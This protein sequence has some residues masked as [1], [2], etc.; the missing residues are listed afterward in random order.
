MN[1]SAM[2][3]YVRRLLNEEGESD[4]F[5][6]DSELTDYINEAYRELIRI[7][8]ADKIGFE[9]TELIDS[10]TYSTTDG[11][12]TLPSDYDRAIYIKYGSY[13][14]TFI[15][16][17]GQHLISDDPWYEAVAV[18]P[19]SYI[20]GGS[21]YVKPAPASATT[22]VLKYV[23]TPA[24]LSGDSD[25]PDIKEIYHE[26]ICLGALERC[27]VKDNEFEEANYSYSRMKKEM[28]AFFNRLT[29]E[30]MLRR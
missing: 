29:P 13:Y 2:R 12:E 27:K 3:N 26:M 8:P 6:S 9:L 10:E 7:F 30:E 15:S 18:E 11:I 28:Y 24:E 23:K 20:D 17:E 1:L 4:G 19:V 16:S 5:Y 14:C 21:L 25:T 22:L